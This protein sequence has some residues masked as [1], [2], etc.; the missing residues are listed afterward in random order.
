[1]IFESNGATGAQFSRAIMEL[2]YPRLFLDEV[3]TEISRK[4]RK[5]PGYHN[6]GE[7]RGILYGGYRQALA[8]EYFLNPSSAAIDECKYYEHQAG[9]GIEHVAASSRKEDASG[10][11][12]N[13]GDRATADALCWRGIV[14]LVPKQKLGNPREHNEPTI[15]DKVAPVGSFLSRRI[16][17]TGKQ[18]ATEYW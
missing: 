9:G 4:K 18:K 12:H 16:E 3:E 7:K 11:G 5:K 15:E 1:L 17:W 8:D 10:A 2:E 6:Q 14:D 13:H